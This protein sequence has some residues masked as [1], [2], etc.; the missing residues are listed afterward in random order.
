MYIYW[1]L[2]KWKLERELFIC[3]PFFLNIVFFLYVP[4]EAVS[5]GIGTV[6]PEPWHTAAL[7]T[8]C[9]KPKTG[10]VRLWI[11]MLLWLQLSMAYLLLR[12][13]GRLSP[14]GK[15]SSYLCNGIIANSFL[16]HKINFHYINVLAEGKFHLYY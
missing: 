16:M 7:V 1:D 5:L 12:K 10:S 8:F 3:F 6:L 13:G 11:L 14:W 9:Q 15:L 4:Q 2:L